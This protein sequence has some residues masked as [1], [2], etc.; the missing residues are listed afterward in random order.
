MHTTLENKNNI[1]DNQESEIDRL[2][3]IY[4]KTKKSL[5]PPVSFPNPRVISLIPTSILC[6]IWEDRLNSVMSF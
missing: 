2:N 6:L 5:I 4:P 1:I 3:K